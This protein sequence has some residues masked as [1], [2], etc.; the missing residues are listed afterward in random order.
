LW[1]GRLIAGLAVGVYDSV[2]KYVDERKQ[3]GVKIKSF[4]LIQE[5]LARM[6][7]SIPGILG[8]LL[9]ISELYDQGKAMIGM[10][11]MVKA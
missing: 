8:L 1:P 11:A 4:Q 9:G 10:I 2:I 7:A 5:K 6:M 3:F